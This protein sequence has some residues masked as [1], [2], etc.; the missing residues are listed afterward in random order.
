M[1]ASL[2]ISPTI[3][4]IY[5]DIRI[6]RQLAPGVDILSARRLDIFNAV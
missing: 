3:L 4:E 6:L 5:G 2:F 1:P